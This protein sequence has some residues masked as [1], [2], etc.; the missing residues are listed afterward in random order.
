MHM[1]PSRATDVQNVSKKYMYLSCHDASDLKNC[2]KTTIKE[3]QL[4]LPFRMWDVTV[5]G[6]VLSGSV[7]PHLVNT[8][9]IVSQ[10]S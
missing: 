5:S 10:V 7:P 4:H 2:Q 9:R 3:K 8:M 1:K 6:H